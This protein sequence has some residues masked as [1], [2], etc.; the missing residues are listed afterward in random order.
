MI[1][2]MNLFESIKSWFDQLANHFTLSVCFASADSFGND[3]TNTLKNKGAS[4]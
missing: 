2:V 3:A 1:C 4:Q